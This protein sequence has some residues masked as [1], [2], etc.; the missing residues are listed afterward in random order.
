[1]EYSHECFWYQGCGAKL[2]DGRGNPNSAC[3]RPPWAHQP[4]RGPSR[5]DKRPCDANGRNRVS[6]TSARFAAIAAAPVLLPFVF[7]TLT[8]AL[9]WDNP[10]LC[11][12]FFLFAIAATVSMILGYRVEGLFSWTAGI[13][14]YYLVYLIAL[15]Y[16]EQIIGFVDYRPLRGTET[17]LAYCAL[18]ILAF[19][20]GTLV[21][22]AI[23]PA[24]AVDTR[25]GLAGTWPFSALQRRDLLTIAF[26]TGACAAYWSIENGYFGL[27]ARAES[28]ESPIAGPV[29]ILSSLVEISLAVSAI[30]AFQH[31]EDQS[32]WRWLLVI[33]LSA[34]LV[35]ALFAYSKSALLRPL[36][37]VALAW[38]LVNRRIPWIGLVTTVAILVVVI[39]PLVVSMR[40]LSQQAADTTF[41]VIELTW[42]LLSSDELQRMALTG[43]ASVGSTETSGI[44]GRSLLIV[45]SKIATLAGDA[46]PYLHGDTY[47][48]SFQTLVPRALWADKANLNVGNFL[49]HLIGMLAP[50]DQVTNVSVTQFGELLLNFGLAGLLLGMFCWGILATWVDRWVLGTQAN[51]VRLILFLNLQWQEAGFAHTLPPFIKQMVVLA[52]LIAAA[53]VFRRLFFV[54]RYRR[55]RPTPRPTKCGL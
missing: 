8:L 39:F 22:R 52:A 51:W 43:Y 23:V 25:T 30:R 3:S 11:L 55:S 13:P 14:L 42:H 21:C 36:L 44:L 16:A 18:G 7:V 9:Y 29:T 47:V 15:P 53:D 10:L 40:Q 26:V 17:A 1:M 38:T 46:I 32:W 6:M 24:I 19:T 31:T 49:G 4:R 50:G 5:R 27:I 28:I 37:V 34:S 54:F 12:A 45:L 20:L 41:G 33:A 35:L 48:A 2:A